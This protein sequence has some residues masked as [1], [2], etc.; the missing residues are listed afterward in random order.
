MDLYGFVVTLGHSNDCSYYARTKQAHT[1]SCAAWHADT[2]HVIMDK[3]TYMYTC[4][5]PS[6]T[7]TCVVCMGLA[8]T[9]TGG[10]V[11]GPLSDKCI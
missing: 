4:M 6:L 11:T 8:L 10:H 9:L 1:H 7:H 3:C 2:T 5:S